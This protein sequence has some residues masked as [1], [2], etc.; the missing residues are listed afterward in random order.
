MAERTQRWALEAALAALPLLGQ[1]GA[2]VALAR[3]Y[4]DDMDEAAVVSTGAARLLEEAGD[5]LPEA[6][7]ERLRA[8]AARVEQTTVLATLGPKYLAV[9][10]ELGMSPRARA[11]V[12]RKG[13]VP[14]DPPAD[15]PLARY[16]AE[17][18]KRLRGGA[19]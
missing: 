5:L 15:N 4:A 14:G 17:R 7:Y 8:L 9:L 1:D 3:R 2:A 13:G 10:A 16:R 12:T 18:N 19:G 6:A 11:D